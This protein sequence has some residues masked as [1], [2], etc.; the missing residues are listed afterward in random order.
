MYAVTSAV[1][2]AP[3]AV[4]KKTNA[5]VAKRAAAVKPVAA[6]KGANEKV[7]IRFFVF[8]VFEV[9]TGRALAGEGRGCATRDA[10]RRIGR[11][12]ERGSR[13]V[14]TDRVNFVSLVSVAT[15][16]VHRSRRPSSVIRRT[17]RRPDRSVIEVVETG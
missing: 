3:I 14:R 2:R 12:R 4:A 8:C 5:T 1:A 13:P 11:R 10:S 9:R 6:V 7:R 16:R 15:G 17:A